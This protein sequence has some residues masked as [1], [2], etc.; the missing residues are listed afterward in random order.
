ME[1]VN[2]D[3]IASSYNDRYQ[4]N[5]LSAVEH[6]LVKFVRHKQPRHILE[7]GCG[8][9]RWLNSIGGMAGGV[10]GLDLSYGMLAQARKD[11]PNLYLVRG[12]AEVLPFVNQSFDLVF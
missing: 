2:Y 5:R 8:T 12:R 7:V 10:F 4:V 3:L 11:N 6:A 9:G 1:S